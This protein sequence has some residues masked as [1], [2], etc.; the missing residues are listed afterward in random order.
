M[1]KGLVGK[2]LTAVLSAFKFIELYK[3]SKFV[4]AGDPYKCDLEH[5]LKP[6]ISFNKINCQPICF[7]CYYQLVVVVNVDRLRVDS[8][9]SFAAI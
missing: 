7:V 9:L 5:A 2:A 3:C 6:I 4:N 1:L 8:S